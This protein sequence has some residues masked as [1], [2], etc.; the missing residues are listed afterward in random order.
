MR[1]RLDNLRGSMTVKPPDI[2]QLT[3]QTYAQNYVCV[4]TVRIY[5][6]NTM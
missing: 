1:V 2:L 6:Y 5:K 3:I 4:H